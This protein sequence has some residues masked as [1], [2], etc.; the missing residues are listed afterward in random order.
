M[1]DLLPYV[2]IA[3]GCRESRP[4]FS[5]SKEW[6][7]HMVSTHSEYWAQ[8]FHREP[9]WKCSVEHENES[10]YQ[11]STSEEPYAHNSLH[12]DELRLTTTLQNCQRLASTCPLCFFKVEENDSRSSE[13]QLIALSSHRKHRVG[14]PQRSHKRVKLMPDPID[15]ER[16]ATTWAMGEHIA[17]HLYHLMLV[18]LLLMV[19]MDY[20]ISTEGDDVSI[21]TPTGSDLSD[22]D[23]N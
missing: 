17:E 9:V 23:G 14:S 10:I 6:Y 5:S 8:D 20:P 19:S 16:K 1:Q 4:T 15:D 7:G 2:C 22:A 21:T 12:H 11:F 18:S 3:E 13:S